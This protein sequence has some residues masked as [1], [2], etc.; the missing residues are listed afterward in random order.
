[1]GENASGKKLWKL[2]LTWRLPS[3]SFVALGPYIY[4]TLWGLFSHTVSACVFH[5]NAMNYWWAC[6]VCS[7]QGKLISDAVQCSK[8]MG[9]WDVATQLQA[10]SLTHF[11]HMQW[12]WWKES[13]VSRCT[14]FRIQKSSILFAVYSMFLKI[15]GVEVVLMACV[16]VKQN[17]LGKSGIIGIHASM[18]R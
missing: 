10:F 3:L 5:C 11:F 7:K 2:A 18:Q 17:T 15:C 12:I 1:M 6:L 16:W 9:K 4:L 14:S 13:L 8:G